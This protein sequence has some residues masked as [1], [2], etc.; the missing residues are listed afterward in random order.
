MRTGDAEH[1]LDQRQQKRK[2]HREVAEFRNHC[3]THED[4]WLLAQPMTA[5][6][7]AYERGVA[8]HLSVIGAPAPS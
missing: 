5:A 8:A 6:G 3:S 2:D 7:A 4:D 1:P